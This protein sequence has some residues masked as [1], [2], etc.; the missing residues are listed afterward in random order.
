MAQEQVNSVIMTD[1]TKV[2]YKENP[3]STEKEVWH[4]KTTSGTWDRYFAISYVGTAIT[5]LYTF[6]AC[7][8]L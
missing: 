7:L 4:I 5:F 2:Y 8:G 6:Y 3:S 1:D